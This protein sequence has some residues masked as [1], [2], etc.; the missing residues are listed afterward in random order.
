MKL[1]S[2]IILT[3]LLA[4]KKIS[5][6]LGKASKSQSWKGVINTHACTHINTPLQHTLMK[7]KGVGESH[8]LFYH[9]ISQEKNADV[10]RYSL[11]DLHNKGGAMQQLA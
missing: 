1:L 10:K 7:G 5:H 3:S 4:S 9:S 11:Q 6:N 2:T 8:Y